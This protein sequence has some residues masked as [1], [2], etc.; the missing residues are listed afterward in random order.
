M[1]ISNPISRDKLRIPSGVQVLD[2]GSGHNPHPR[3]NVVADKFV[4]TNYH[5]SNNIK[6]LKQQRFVQADGENMPFAD[7]EFGYVICCHVLEHV[8]RPENFYTEMQRVAKT[9]Y[10]ETPSLIG[11]MLIPKES[12]QWVILDIDNTIVMVSKKRL[13]FHASHDFGDLFLDYLP[14]ISIAYK[15]LQRTQPQLLTVNYEWKDKIDFIIEPNNEDLMRFFNSPWDLQMYERIIPKRSYS[16]ELF[17]A[18]GAT[19]DIFKSVVKSKL[20]S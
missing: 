16:S 12:H 3:A 4:D 11:E 5:R 17:S 1:K 18:M 13:G 19:L 14:K 6:V 8:D 7:G 2:I 10:V 20:L 9:G 15:M